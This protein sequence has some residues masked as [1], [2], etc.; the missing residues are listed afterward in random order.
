MD[1]VIKVDTTD[2]KLRQMSNQI[3]NMV[4]NTVKEVVEKIFQESQLLVPVNTGAL[5]NS[6]E[7][8]DEEASMDGTFTSSYVTYGNGAVNYA[9]K[10]HE[11]LEM[12]H[13]APTRAKFLE[14]PLVQN[15]KVLESLIRQRLKVILN[16]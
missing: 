16:S 12:Y 10:V 5:K 7:I 11:D 1:I 14:I 15:R 4:R 9:V 8:I 13:T 6:G 3:N 2:L